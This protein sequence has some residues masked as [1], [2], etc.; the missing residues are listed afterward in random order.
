MTRFPPRTRNKSEAQSQID[1]G[2]RWHRFLRLAAATGCGDDP[3]HTG[4]GYWTIDRRKCPAAG[5]G[6]NRCRGACTGTGEF[7]FDRVADPNGKFSES[8][9]RH[10]AGGDSSARGERGS[11]RVSRAAVGPG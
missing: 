11:D 4:L 5:V 1:A 9:E 7:V 8:P 3:G 6:A 2:L 10:S